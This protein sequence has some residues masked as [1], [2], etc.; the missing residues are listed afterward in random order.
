MAICSTSRLA[1]RLPT[2]S[3]PTS[4]ARETGLYWASHVCAT[5]KHRVSRRGLCPSLTILSTVLGTWDKPPNP[6]PPC[7]SASSPPTTLSSAHLNPESLS[8]EAGPAPSLLLAPH[9]EATTRASQ[10]CASSPPS[11]EPTAPSCVPLPLPELWP[12][13]AGGEHAGPRFAPS[14]APPGPTLLRTCLHT[15][16]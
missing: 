5:A 15:P 16:F 3:H 8:G 10:P 2:H 7:V 14:R 4:L 9:S 13:V 6:R 12:H 11:T 1:C